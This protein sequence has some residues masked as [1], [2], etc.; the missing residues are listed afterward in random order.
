MHFGFVSSVV[1]LSLI[2]TVD[3]CLVKGVKVDD[4]FE[5]SFEHI[6]ENTATIFANCPS[7][8]APE[9]SPDTRKIVEE[10]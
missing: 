8:I 3:G 1:A 7:S 2:G 5:D 4:S 9:V 10:I 6:K